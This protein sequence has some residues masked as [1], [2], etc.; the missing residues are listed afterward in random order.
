MSWPAI[1]RLLLVG[2]AAALLTACSAVKLAYNNLPDL[3]YWWVDGYAD[4]GD[5][6]SVRFRS[7]LARLHEWHRVNEMPRIADLLQQIGRDTP[8]D[9]TAGD[10]CRFFDQL[11]ERFDAVSRQAEPGAV[12][13]A[14]SLTP[15]Q[16]A[17]IEG[18]FDKGN[19]EWRRKWVAVDRAQRLERRF[20]ST[21]E[22]A[23]QFYGTLDA[24]QRAVLQAGL[25]RSSWDPQRSFT[26]RQRRQQDLLQTLRTVSGAGGAARPTPQQAAGLLRAYLERTARSPDPAYRTH[27]QT[28]IEEN[29][30]LYAQL[31]NSTTAAQRARAV[32]RVAAYERDARELS[33]AP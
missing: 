27:A 23:E 22:R 19:A 14:A 7:D 16:L 33:G 24:R 26:E 4:L 32:D 21:L 30:Q 25:A 10:V 1:I 9:T 17:H 29:C 2:L 20:A 6:Q 31:H 15:A 8:A 5:A 3:G 13:L 11:R 12:M 28:T 18:K